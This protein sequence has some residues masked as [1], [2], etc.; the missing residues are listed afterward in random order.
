MSR[1]KD[2]RN[3]TEDDMYDL[4]DDVYYDDDHYDYDD[5]YTEEEN[6]AYYLEQERVKEEEEA[7]KKKKQQQQKQQTQSK[8]S[9]KKKVGTPSISMNTTIKK[10]SGVSKNPNNNEDAEK[11]REVTSM[12]FSSAQARLA[13]ERNSWDL[14]MA[15]NELL[16]SNVQEDSDKNKK[17]SSSSPVSKPKSK[18]DVKKKDVSGVMAPPPGWGRPDDSN[19]VK[20]PKGKENK[21]TP[22]KIAKKN[23]VKLD[24]VRE[25]H[26]RP[27]KK[28]SEELIGQIKEQKSRLGCVI[29]G[30]VDAGK[31]TLMGQVLVQVGV[32]QKRTISKFQRQAAQIGKASFALAWVMDEDES[33]RERGV[34]IDIATKFISTENH[35]LTI[36][37]SPGHADF[38]PAMIT[39]AASADVGI[40]VI[41]ATPGEFESGF[42][43]TCNSGFAKGHIGQTRE[44]VTLS[45]GLGVSQL[46]VA[47]NKLDASEPNWSQGRFLEIKR[48]LVPFLKANGFDMKRVQFIPISGLSGVNINS[49]PNPNDSDSAG[50]AKWYNGR[51]LMQAINGFQPAKRNIDKA[52]RFLVSD[53]YTEGKYVSVKGRVVQGVISVGDKAAILPIG[54]EVDIGRIEHGIAV[55]GERMNVAVAGDSA[56]LFLTGID[57]ARIS[58]GNIISDV[59]VSLRPSLKK[60]MKAKIMVMDRL[61]VPII[62][63]SQVLLHMHSVSVPAVISKLISATNRIDGIENDRPRVLKGSS[64]A[65]VEIRLNKKLC[66]EPFNE[67]RALGR[68]ALRRGG[69]TVAVGI[70]ESLH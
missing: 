70:V 12:G 35:E 65:M 26:V 50:L 23:P 39:G 8:V 24:T 10:P 25:M 19:K 53:V 11:E 31:S 15:V 63:G 36:L 55:D 3:L 40:L 51:S 49:P 32:V 34:T 44:H 67:C 64:T 57:I 59:D 27:K 1:H 46:I 54:D 61:T 41:A 30:H 14:E 7:K 38:V 16:N 66:L 37:D 48:R 56:Q 42:D 52:F 2:I 60:R 43:D 22:I 58:I 68:F 45:R 29:L 33:E 69:D 6:K 13:L 17:L 47:V 4:Y 9:P 20:T 18:T 21:S 5:N 28:I 62:Q